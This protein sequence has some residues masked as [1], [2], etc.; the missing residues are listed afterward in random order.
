ML[1]KLRQVFAH[2]D[3]R[4]RIIFVVGILVL[5]RILAHVPVPGIDITQIQ[6]F[7]EQN[8]VFGL[9]NLF[10]GGGLSNFSIAMMGLGPYIT[11]AIIMQ[12]LTM[13]V[14][15]FEQ[16]QQEGGEAGRRKISQ[17]TRLMT[18]PLAALQAFGMIRLLQAQTVGGQTILGRIHP[19][20]PGVVFCAGRDQSGGVV[21]GQ[22]QVLRD[23]LSRGERPLGLR[24]DAAGSAPDRQQRAGDFLARGTIGL[25]VSEIGGAPGA[26]VLAERVNVRRIARG[27]EVLE[28]YFAGGA[29]SPA[30]GSFSP[31]R[32][33]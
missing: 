12:L 29:R 8:Q 21:G 13:A 17:Y 24:R 14:P 20:G 22:V 16:L 33:T 19:L 11:A 32:S 31:G 27:A 7:F 28:L 15:K 18:V 23:G 3:L 25:V 1:D 10:S 30:G 4:K 9:V 2:K 5:T 26:I 6:T